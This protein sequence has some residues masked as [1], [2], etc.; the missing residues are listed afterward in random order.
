[1]SLTRDDWRPLSA[2]FATV[3]ESMQTGEWKHEFNFRAMLAIW[4]RDHDM[5]QPFLETDGGESGNTGCLG[6][7]STQTPQIELDLATGLLVRGEISFVGTTGESGVFGVVRV[8]IIAFADADGY[9]VHVK[10]SN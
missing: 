9:H 3:A 1:M 7:C 8:Q 6:I 4:L 5:A 2:L 10:T